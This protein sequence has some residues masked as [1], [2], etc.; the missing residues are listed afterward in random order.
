M[1]LS[2]R[3]LAPTERVAFNTGAYYSPQGQRIGVWLRDV[4]QAH[5]QLCCLVDFDRGITGHFPMRLTSSLRSAE[6]LARHAKYMYDM[7]QYDLGCPQPLD[8]A[9]RAEVLAVLSAGYDAF[10]RSSG[11]HELFVRIDRTGR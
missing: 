8:A 4:P 6:D 2:L 7:G 10:V 9:I 5:L 3:L 1:L 11:T